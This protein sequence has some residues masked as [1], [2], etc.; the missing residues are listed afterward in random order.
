MRLFSVIP[1]VGLLLSVAAACGLDEVP[2]ASSPTDSGAGA[3]DAPS[4]DGSVSDGGHEE[5]PTDA[6]ADAAPCTPPGTPPTLVFLNRSGGTYKPGP[7]DSRTNTS[8]MLSSASTAL[9]WTIADDSW[10]TLIACVNQKFLPFNISVTDVDPGSAEHLEVVFADG[11]FPALKN[12]ITSVAPLKCSPVANA[13][14]FVSQTYAATPTNGCAAAAS[15][16]A[17]SLGLEYV[18]SCPDALSF[19]QTDC[20]SAAF[21]DVALPCGTTA[22]EKCQCG[23]GTTQNSFA[24]LKTVA[25]PRCL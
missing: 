1:A 14:S 10:K 4:V 12:G 21:T 16:V 25:G 19:E 13:I 20:A 2:S 5:A 9:A 15:N 7:D 6:A 22:A 8:S 24:R 18:T 11:S 3:Q 17:F 23:G